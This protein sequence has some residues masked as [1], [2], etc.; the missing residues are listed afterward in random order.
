MYW[1]FV[2][3]DACFRVKRYSISDEKK[4]PIMDEGMAY[5]VPS[6]PYKAQVKK[7]KNQAPVS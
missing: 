4:D 6:G 7:Y 3:L 2:S 5:F 1:L